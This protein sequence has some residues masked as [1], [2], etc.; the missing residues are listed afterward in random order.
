MGK[1]FPT[2]QNRVPERLTQTLKITE[3]Q[4]SIECSKTGLKDSGSR[5]RR[6]LTHHL[7]TGQDSEASAAKA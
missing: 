2:Y 5:A 6:F 4:S 1:L 3:D 7:V